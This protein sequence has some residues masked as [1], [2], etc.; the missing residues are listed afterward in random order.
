[1]RCRGDFN[2]KDK[3]F[4]NTTQHQKDTT[5]TYSAQNE[6]EMKAQFVS[7]IVKKEVA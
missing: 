6:E 4:Q 1:M 7:A 2:H 5:Y 3:A